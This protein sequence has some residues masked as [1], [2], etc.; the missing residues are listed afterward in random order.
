MILNRVNI[1]SEKEK[2]KVNEERRKVKVK[3]KEKEKEEEKEEKEEEEEEEEEEEIE[4]EDNHSKKMFKSK[5]INKIKG[6]IISF[7]NTIFQYKLLSIS[8]AIFIVLLLLLI[9]IFKKSDKGKNEL[10]SIFEKTHNKDGNS[11]INDMEKEKEQKNTPEISK[12]DEEKKKKINDELISAYNTNGEINIIKYFE[13]TINQKTYS[14]DTSQLNNIHINIGFDEKNIDTAIKHIA[15]ILYHSEE[16][17][18][19]HLHMMDADTF[20]YDSLLKLKTMVYKINNNTEIIVYNA[21][22]AL[23]DFKIKDGATEKF[24]KEYAKLY[25][26]K[27]IKDVQKIIFLDSDV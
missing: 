13:E 23:K 17:T 25:A 16:K 15:S 6:Y 5:G 4:Y 3:K 27:I 1:E 26:F 8:L 18:F 22:P 14:R 24:A 11:T 7:I 21:S 12:E 9:I 20:S 19:I 10:T 2:I